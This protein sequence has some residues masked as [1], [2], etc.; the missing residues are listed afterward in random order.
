MEKLVDI[1]CNLPAFH[2]CHRGVYSEDSD[3]DVVD[4][5]V[6]S[7]DDDDVQDQQMSKNL[8]WWSIIRFFSSKTLNLNIS[9]S[10]SRFLPP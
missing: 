6:Q 5:G 10:K 3:G 2:E 4:C 1:K 9:I 8:G 7:S